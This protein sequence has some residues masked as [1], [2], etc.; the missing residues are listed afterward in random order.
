HAIAFATSNINEL[1]KNR[2]GLVVRWV[3]YS[4]V[5]EI[6]TYSN[7]KVLIN[8]YQWTQWTEFEKQPDQHCGIKTYV[9]YYNLRI[10]KVVQSATSRETPPTYCPATVQYKH[11]W[12]RACKLFST[13]GR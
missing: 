1:L 8:N 2:V 4:E 13:T 10:I 6:E 3:P 11:T 5:P 12:E 7:C 9:R